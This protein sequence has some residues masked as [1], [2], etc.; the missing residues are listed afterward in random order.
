MPRTVDAALQQYLTLLT[1]TP[2]ERQVAAIHRASIET[3]LRSELSVAEVRETGSFSHGTG[4]RGR[5]DVDLIVALNYS[6]PMNPSTAL[7]WVRDALVD[8][9][10]RTTI[11][12]SSPTVVVSFAGG[13]EVFEVAPGFLS[14][15]E[16]V[17]RYWIPRP[18]TGWMETA[19]AAHLRYVTEV[20]KNPQDGAKALT[21]LLKAWKAA[22]RVPVS[23]F[24]LEMAAAEHMVGESYFD[25]LSDL[26]AVLQKLN[27]S[28]FRAL[29]DPTGQ[30]GL[31]HATSS[32]GGYSA[33]MSAVQ[34][35]E[36]NAR[37]AFIAR[38]RGQELTAFGLL[39]KI[40]DRSFP[41]YA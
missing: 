25:P 13:D 41:D 14:S 36:H 15:T 4:L 11:R 30:T 40:F 6:R 33:A 7:H 31:I 3:R 16:P 12:T 2:T 10:P 24:Y 17:S 29:T 27:S 34:D 18:P 28:Q 22:R 20:N 32:L 39:H 21:R 23:S 19:P 9:F 38:A 1:P 35:A 26:Q 5:S 8:R 37:Q